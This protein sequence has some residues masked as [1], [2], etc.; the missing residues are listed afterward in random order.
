MYILAI[1]EGKTRIIITIPDE[2]KK[3]LETMC[4]I[5]KRTMSQEVEYILER[6]IL[7]NGRKYGLDLQPEFKFV[8][9]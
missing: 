1:K 4:C 2:L 9:D 3:H 8:E 6:H 5:D 7:V